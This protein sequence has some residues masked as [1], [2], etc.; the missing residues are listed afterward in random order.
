M[1]LI[2]LWFKADGSI[3]TS[4]SLQWHVNFLWQWFKWMPLKEWTFFSLKMLYEGLPTWS[5]IRHVFRSMS[6]KLVFF[7][8]VCSRE[9]HQKPLDKKN[10]N[11]SYIINVLWLISFSFTAPVQL[12]ESLDQERC[13]VLYKTTFCHD[14]LQD[15]LVEKW[16]GLFFLLSEWWISYILYDQICIGQRWNVLLL[17]SCCGLK[18]RWLTK[19]NYYFLEDLGDYTKLWPF[20]DTH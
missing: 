5:I 3:I 7:R 2:P 6:W 11:I 12:A 10:I 16:E 20:P 19:L 15:L 9:I 17:Y 14:S 13:S 4:T 8:K 1:C 18:V